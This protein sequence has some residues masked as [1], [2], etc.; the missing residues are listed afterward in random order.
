VIERWEGRTAVVTGAAS[1]I[2][3]AMATAFAARGMRVVL[4]DVEQGA[5]DEATSTL[6]AS[7]ATVV[8]VQ[9]DVSNAASV[10]ALAQRVADEFGP[11]HLLCNNAGVT[12]LGNVW[13]HTADDWSWVIGVNLFGVANGI[14]AFVPAMIDHGDEAHVVN[15]ASTVGLA[16]YAGNALYTASKHAVVAVSEVLWRD[17]R[18]AGS[19]VGASVLCPGRVPTR[20]GEAPRNRPASLPA[21]HDDRA[22]R[23]EIE[24]GVPRGRPARE[25]GE[26]VADAVAAGTFYI[27]TDD[28]IFDAVRERADRILTGRPPEV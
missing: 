1:G 25:V 24:S 7:G 16:T 4:A 15:T 3:N 13:E 21:M 17:L 14:R 11:V 26:L 5:L 18:D 22:R 20:L 12:V 9:V 27:F 10:D 8:G 2:G 28:S 19:R 6:T 23:D